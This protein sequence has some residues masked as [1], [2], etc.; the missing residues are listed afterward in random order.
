MIIKGISPRRNENDCNFDYNLHKEK[1]ND[2]FR[3]YLHKWFSGHDHYYLKA[4][5]MKVLDAQEELNNKISEWEQSRREGD[6]IPIDF[7]I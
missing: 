2:G 1:E 5:T 6:E 4:A 7:Q 3:F